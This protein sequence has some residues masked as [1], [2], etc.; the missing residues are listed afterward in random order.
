MVWAVTNQNLA[1]V[2]EGMDI[3]EDNRLI[4]GLVSKASDAETMV[5]AM[6]ILNVPPQKH[7]EFQK[8]VKSAIAQIIAGRLSVNGGNFHTVT[9]NSAYTGLQTTEQ[10]MMYLAIVGKAAREWHDYFSDIEHYSERHDYGRPTI[11][12]YQWL[13]GFKPPQ[14]S[15]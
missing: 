11:S 7:Q 13:L 4:D 15:K 12:L 5:N 14:T 6:Q 9:D 10:R 3:P 2:K 8:S 1:A